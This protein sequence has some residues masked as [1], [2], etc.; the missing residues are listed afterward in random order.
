MSPPQ[1][2]KTL[3]KEDGASRGMET[4]VEG[5]QR[6]RAWLLDSPVV[7]GLWLQN[8]RWGVRF[9]HGASL[10]AAGLHDPGGP[11]LL[12]RS[13]VI[14]WMSWEGKCISSSLWI[15]MSCMPDLLDFTGKEIFLRVGDRMVAFSHGRAFSLH[16]SLKAARTVS[17]LRRLPV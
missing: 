2:K 13:T 3:P 8:Q 4:F 1:K 15:S 6:W 14:N 16:A 17:A 12:C 7:L 11:F 5:E 10:T 9:P